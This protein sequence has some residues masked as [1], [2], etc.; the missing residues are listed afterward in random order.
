MSAVRTKD[1]SPEQRALILALLAQRK[2][3]AR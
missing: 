3:A 1:L 2:R